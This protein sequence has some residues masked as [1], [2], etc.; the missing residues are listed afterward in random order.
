MDACRNLGFSYVDYN[1]KCFA[2][3]SYVQTRQN[4][5]FRVTSEKAY[6][7]PVRHRKNLVVLTG[8]QVTR[9]ILRKDDCWK[10]IGVQYFKNDRYFIAR[11]SK[12]IIVADGGY[13]S[14]K[15]LMLS[16]IGPKKHLEQLKIPV[17]IDLPVGIKIQ[18]HL[19]LPGIHYED[20]GD[21]TAKTEDSYD[22]G[23]LEELV[24]N[25]TGPLSIPFY[26]E[27]FLHYQT[28]ISKNLGRN[29][30][31][32]RI[33][34]INGGFSYD[35][36]TIISNYVNTSK[37][38]YKKTFE[39]FEGKRI[40]SIYSLLLRPETYGSLQLK[41]GNLFDPPRLFGNFLANNLDLHK[42]LDAVRTCQKIV[43]SPC[44][45]KYRPKLLKIVPPGCEKYCF[46][47]DKFWVCFF[48][49]ASFLVENAWGACR[50]GQKN[51]PEAVLDSECRVRGVKNLRVVDESSFPFALT[52]SV[53]VPTAM[54]GE[55]IADVIKKEYCRGKIER[56]GT[57]SFL[58]SPIKVFFWPEIKRR[59][60]EGAI[61]AE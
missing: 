7:R 52:G 51:D 60:V 22:P 4:H 48:R 29:T 13:N 27:T 32:I 18:S 31:D 34:A 45:R 12:E 5:G 23:Y 36:G 6:I 1:G 39:P 53:F 40:F 61:K 24:K 2:G 20:K 56:K 3:V 54:A 38:F 50:M 11:A 9:L 55:K 43:N 8:S 14:P 33:M 21:I 59:G 49:R 26:L 47:T 17:N 25:G 41:S 37:S 19:C 10:A 58:H 35:N 44:F 57:K 30:P 15:L 16:G 28:K 42:A 46:D